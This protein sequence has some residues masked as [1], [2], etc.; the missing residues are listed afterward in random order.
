MNYNLSETL[1]PWKFWFHKK[2]TFKGA[3]RRHMEWQSTHFQTKS[4]RPFDNGK[5][6]HKTTIYRHHNTYYFSREMK[7]NWPEKAI[8]I[9][10]SGK[11]SCV[12]QETQTTFPQKWIWN[13][14]RRQLQST[15]LARNL[16][17]H[18]AQ[19]CGERVLSTHFLRQAWHTLHSPKASPNCPLWCEARNPASSCET[20]KKSPLLILLQLGR[21]D[22]ELGF[23]EVCSSGTKFSRRWRRSDGGREVVGA[24][25][26]GARSSIPSPAFQGLECTHSPQSAPLSFNSRLTQESVPARLS[27][28]KEQDLWLKRF[29]FKRRGQDE[30]EAAFQLLLSE[31]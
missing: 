19:I 14:R 23:C 7:M 4:R 18:R 25:I 2:S 3:D 17:W 6:S 24:E 27:P 5:K 1:S 13:D 15:Y 8:A 12:K 29:K 9:S 31:L 10:I 22:V 26:P 30:A 28:R 16:V 20:H 11:K 21:F